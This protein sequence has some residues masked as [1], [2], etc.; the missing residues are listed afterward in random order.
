MVYSTASSQVKKS[1]LC[2]KIKTFQIPFFAVKLTAIAY[3]RRYGQQKFKII[4]IFYFIRSYVGLKFLNK[5][6]D[7]RQDSRLYIAYD[8]VH[9]LQLAPLTHW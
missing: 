6:V 2:K 5:P 4:E 1:I 8:N 9:S 7:H 3:L